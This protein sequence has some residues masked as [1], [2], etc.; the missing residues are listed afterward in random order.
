MKAMRLKTLA[1]ALGLLP[2]VVF[3]ASN[4]D[5]GTTGSSQ[6]TVTIHGGTSGQAVI[7]TP[8]AAGSTTF[9]LPVGNGSAGQYVKGDGAGNLF[10][11]DGNKLLSLSWA[12][13]QNLSNISIPIGRTSVSATATGA[14]CRIE[15]AVGGT[16]TASIY[17]AA[18]GTACASGTKIET[19][20]CNANGTAVTTQILGITN[21]AITANTDICVVFPTNAAWATSVGSGM[22][23]LAI[24]QP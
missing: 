8:A 2:S 1:F 3:A 19:T 6:G 18:S 11:G 20:A 9:N 15:T 7:G 22:V 24:T 12:P 21:A 17:F 14:V 13:G 5:V 23:Q 16:A 4:V 10:Y